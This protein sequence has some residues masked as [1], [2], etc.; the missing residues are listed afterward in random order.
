MNETMIL[1]LALVAGVLLGGVF[2]GGLWWTIHRL[3][4]SKGSA[5][6]FP[7]SLLI[8]TG[9]TLA[10]FY[11]VSRGHWQR[12]LVCLLGFLIARVVVM[13]LTRTAV[14]KHPGLSKEGAGRAP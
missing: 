8:R 4:S 3:I 14:E 6:W 1:V 12:L 10:G 11:F 2:F 13:R 7:G 5:F 9:I